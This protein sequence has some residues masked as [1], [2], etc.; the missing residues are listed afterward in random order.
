M[1]YQKILNL[2]QRTT[3]QPSNGWTKDSVKNNRDTCRIFKINRKIKF[4]T[5]NLESILFDYSN[6]YIFVKET[7]KAVAADNATNQK[8][9]FFNFAPFIDSLSYCSIAVI[10][11][12]HLKVYFN[13]RKITP[14]NQLEII[15]T[16]LFI[17]IIILIL[18]H[19]N[20]MKN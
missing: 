15:I 4:K 9:I 1:Q 8:K 14:F 12:K 20:S 17:L 13:I 6:S 16:I 3:T 11:W 19:L 10:I 5:S 7:I 18:I 2:L